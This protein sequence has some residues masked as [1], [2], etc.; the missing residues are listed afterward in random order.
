MMK[1]LQPQPLEV[2]NKK[3]RGRKVQQTNNSNNPT[4]KSYKGFRYYSDAEKVLLSPSNW[5]TSS[6]SRNHPPT[7]KP[8]FQLTTDPIDQLLDSGVLHNSNDDNNSTVISNDTTQIVHLFERF[9]IYSD[10]G[11]IVQLRNN[12]QHQIRSFLENNN[13]SKKNTNYN[14]ESSPRL[15]NEQT[16]QNR[17]KRYHNEQENTNTH[18]N[19]LPQAEYPCWS[20]LPEIESIEPEKSNIQRRKRVRSGP[21]IEIINSTQRSPSNV[22]SNRNSININIDPTISIARNS[23]NNNPMTLEFDERDVEWIFK[24]EE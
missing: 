24:E 16:H 18:R 17:K 20:V 12:R 23:N 1:P 7:S 21:H 22:G 10:H 15:A 19:N 4:K 13:N 11:N 3:K 14:N 9:L 5:T 6:A 2:L 8:Q